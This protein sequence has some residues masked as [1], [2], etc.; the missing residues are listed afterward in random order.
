MGSSQVVDLLVHM[1]LPVGSLAW[2]CVPSPRL[3]LLPPWGSLVPCSYIRGV[4]QLLDLLL[5]CFG[6]GVGK[7]SHPTLIRLSHH[8]RHIA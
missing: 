4:P 3:Q 5:Q 1:L 7:R 6:L 8:W 2:S